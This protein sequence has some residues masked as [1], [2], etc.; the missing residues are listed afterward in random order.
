MLQALRADLPKR[1]TGRVHYKTHEDGP[2]VLKKQ[3]RGAQQDRPRASYVRRIFPL[4]R[5]SEL[6]KPVK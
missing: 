2:F 5:V 6:E 4:Q 1:L 3:E